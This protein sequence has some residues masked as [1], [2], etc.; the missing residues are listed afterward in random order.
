MKPFMRQ[1]KRLIV[2]CFAIA[3]IML[4]SMLRHLF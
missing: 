3:A 1:E 2:L 4:V